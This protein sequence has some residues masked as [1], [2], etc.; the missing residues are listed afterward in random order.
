MTDKYAQ[1]VNHG[2]GK[3]VATQIGLPRPPRLRR[4]EPGQE[5]LEGAAAVGGIGDTAVQQAVTGIITASGG[6]VVQATADS[7]YADKPAAVVFDATGARTLEELET[8]RAVMGPAVKALGRCGRV[9]I[10]GTPPD[11]LDDAQ[12]AA[13]QQALEGITRS[14]G[15]ELRA[16][17]TANLLWL[18]GDAQGDSSAL[19]APLR[20]FLSSR[21]AYVSGQPVRVG[22]GDIPEVDD[23]HHP[24]QGEI[25]VIT[26][27]ARG[28][29][30]EIAKVFARAGAQVIAVDIPAAG[31]ALT[32]VANG[33]GAIALQLDI[34]SADA[35]E[36]IAEAVARK[37]DHLDVIVHNAGI[38][39]DKLFVNTDADRWGSVIDVNLASQ[40][41]IN[42]VLLDPGTKG[43]LKDG[44]RI[45]AVASTSGIGGNRGQAN[46][47]A[48]KAGV[49]GMVRRL[50]KDLADRHITVN[51]VA[52]GFIETEMTSKIP[53]GTREVGRRINSLMQGGQPVD[54]G[55]TIAFFAEP[56][57]AGVTGQVLRVCGQ[58][59]LGA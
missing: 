37:G 44:G 43:G 41:R 36:R 55:E 50:S 16:G 8:L 59:Q 5:L 53:L 7:T 11:E 29:G 30:A 25:A 18:Q 42:K 6:T 56:G 9:V 15:K 27:A 13:T 51:A 54:V 47:A 26:G 52:P 28:I 33:I 24:L 32:K 49:I 10:I 38:T 34:T 14:I 35:G 31:D 3:K 19:A 1:L 45:V 17:G 58:S 40:F 57:S 4:F 46:Y 20:F 22:A 21:S 2:I 12:A 23:W 48:S 39:R